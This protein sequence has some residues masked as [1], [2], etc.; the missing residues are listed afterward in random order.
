LHILIAGGSGYLG[1]N[2]AVHLSRKGHQVV[3]G[4][5][6]SIVSPNW[7]SSIRVEELEWGSAKSLAKN[8]RNIDI[9]IQAA[10]MNAEDCI[11]DPM[12]ALE[13]NGS[14][15]SRLVE[16]AQ[17]QGVKRFI[18]LS[19][20]HVYGSPL[21]GSLNEESVTLN[22]HPY[23]TSH[24]AGEAS[25]KKA[26]EGGGTEG[27]VMRLSNVYGAPID[28]QTN[29]WMLLVND[30]CRQIIEKGSISLHTDGSQMR[31]FIP[32]ASFT[33]VVEALLSVDLKKNFEI[34][35]VG[36]GS[37]LTIKDM[38][39]LV[40]ARCNTLL[41]FVPSVK[42]RPRDLKKNTENFIYDCNKLRNFGVRYE[43]FRVS[44]IDNLIS[45]CK[46]QFS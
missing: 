5:R 14:A 34:F 9:V 38:T 36:S 8:C 43:D 29:C 45:F 31:D 10:G 42:A 30:I 6:N 7:P 15:T 39:E 17:A 16:C 21:V 25:I 46:E 4:A 35:N 40:Q 44:E 27:I 41:G 18:Y 2:L 26:C 20:A 13:F 12:G 37:S 33:K 23:A 24:L 32:M 22:Q 11:K 19:T 3:V 1:S 28:V